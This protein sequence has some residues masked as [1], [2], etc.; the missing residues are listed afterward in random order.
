MRLSDHNII[1]LE[2]DDDTRY[3]F[4]TIVQAVRDYVFYS[5]S[6]SRHRNKSCYR[7]AKS[8]IMNPRFAVEWGDSDNPPCFTFNEALEMLG[9][10]PENADIFRQTIRDARRAK[11][12]I[13]RS[14]IVK[15][16]YGELHFHDNEHDP[17]GWVGY[18]PDGLSLRTE[19]VF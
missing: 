19:E 9:V 3:L 18:H 17:F 6:N 15:K 14:N 1:A 2:V 13:E 16:A 5:P 10:Y 4:W 7:L 11:T 12:K 8:W